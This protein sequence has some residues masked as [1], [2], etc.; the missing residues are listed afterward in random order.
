MPLQAP[1]IL[2]FGGVGQAVAGLLA[3]QGLRVM[4]ADRAAPSGGVPSGVEFSTVNAADASAVKALLKGRDAVISCLPFHL[5]LGVAKAA[6]AAGVHYFDATEDVATTG[7]VQDM[8]RT[9]RAAM[10][11]QCGLAPGFICIIGAHLARQFDAGKLRHL[12]LRVGALPQNPIGQLGYAGNWSLEGLVHEYIAPCDAIIDGKPQKVPPLRNPEILRVDG[13]EYEAFTTSGGIGTLTETFAGKVETLNYKSIRYPGHLAGMRLLLE[14]MRFREEPEALVKRLANA[15]P[16][17]EQD[18]VLI[19]TSAQGAVDGRLQTREI[20]LDYRPITV[21]GK[22]RT[23]IV[24]TTAAAIVAVVEL[25]RQ[26]ALP[27]KNFVR[28]ED[29]PLKSFLKTPSGALYAA[30]SPKLA[31][32]ADELP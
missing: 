4:A 31:A 1:L 17:D 22:L 12:R 5:T 13:V 7:V 27:Q 24:W 25:V 15:L 16:P 9:A 21:A 32:I 2:G 19:H 26:G 29:I 3:E 10:V 14:E 18:R 8:A 23:A 30:H 20:V 11:P 28:Q 6:H